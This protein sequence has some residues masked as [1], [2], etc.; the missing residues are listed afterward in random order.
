MK[1][2]ILTF[3]RYYLPG[4]KAGGPIRTVANMVARLGDEFDFKIVALDRDLGDKHSYPNAIVNTWMSCGRAFVRYV[5]PRRFYLHEIM[6]ILHST[7][8]DV[9]YLNSFF[10]PGFTQQVMISR[11]L[12]RLGECPVVI[13]P[14][15]EFS[16]N[17]LKIKFWRKWFFIKLVKLLGLYSNV[18]WQ[19]SSIHEAE[20]IRRVMFLKN[21][22]IDRIVVCGNVAALPVEASPV[23][24][25]G[26]LD[27]SDDVLKLCTL[28]RISPMKNLDYAL[29]VLAL[30]RVRAKFTIY[31]P[32][33][34]NPYWMY[35]QKLIARLPVNIQ[36]VYEGAVSPDDAVST[37]SRHDLFLFPTRGENFGHVI[38]EAM[39]A[40][41]V[42]LISDQTPWRDLEAK[43][44]GWDLPLSS[45]ESF[46]RCIEAVA[47]WNPE[48]RQR[49]GVRA[50][51]FAAR[52]GSSHDTLEANRS[53][54]LNVMKLNN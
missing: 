9:I 10:D 53:L 24:G 13:A 25:V 26:L 52:V 8:H 27:S 51:D 33:E 5:S 2:I 6:R 22:S 48:R 19:A 20:D 17:A 39:S 23:N 7:A 54:F 11:W 50:C 45:P 29:G 14:R 3:V 36:V 15:G 44:V 18:T 41:L 40:G 30:V 34:D 42:V 4:Y 37:L 38:H 35:C 32:I 1:P 47:G 46:A 43:E 49:W 31:G 28:S 12:G 21:D 16:A